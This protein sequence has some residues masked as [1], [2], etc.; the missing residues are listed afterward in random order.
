MSAWVR[1]E[2]GGMDFRVQRLPDITFRAR[3]NTDWVTKLH[4]KDQVVVLGQ[5]GY[6]MNVTCDMLG[7]KVTFRPTGPPHVGFAE[8]VHKATRPGTPE[9][10]LSIGEFESLDVKHGG[11]AGFTRKG[12]LATALEESKARIAASVEKGIRDALLEPILK[13][14]PVPNKIPKN[15]LAK[16]D[17]L[18]RQYSRHHWPPG[19]PSF[20]IHDEVVL[21]PLTTKEKKMR[22]RNKFYVAAPAVTSHAEQ[23]Q[24]NDK[25]KVALAVSHQGGTGAKWTRPSLKDALLHAEQILEGN[26]KQ[27]HVAIVQIVRIVRRKKQPI[28]VETVR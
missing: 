23:D 26:P 8:A 7:L 22:V 6:V 19:Y 20:V 28:V 14:G 25:D 13:G 5:P 9:R 15:Y 24:V 21:P 3:H 16:A 18:L 27:D 4:N 10:V 2:F 17:D 12:F 11:N 1:D